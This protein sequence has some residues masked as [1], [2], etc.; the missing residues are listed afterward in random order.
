MDRQTDERTGDSTARYA[1]HICYMLLRA[2]KWKKFLCKP[3]GY[4]HKHCI[5]VNA[6]Q[7]HNCGDRC[8]AAAGP[9]LWNSLP[10][11]LQQADIIA[12]NDLSGY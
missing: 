9:P 10:S 1:M 5:V 4:I 6:M 7:L 11:E 3:A 2:N 12:F 8:F